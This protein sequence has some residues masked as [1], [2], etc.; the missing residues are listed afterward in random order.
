M[1]QK[2]IDISA[3]PTDGVIMWNTIFTVISRAY[4]MRN[5]G[6]AHAIRD[7]LL[8]RNLYG[9]RVS[10]SGNNKMI[11]TSSSSSCQW[12]AEMYEFLAVSWD[13]CEPEQNLL[14]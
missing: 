14:Y 3:F 1:A 7:S 9:Q 11:H 12:R 8:T 2:A 13:S 6:G 10:D 5:A 4:E